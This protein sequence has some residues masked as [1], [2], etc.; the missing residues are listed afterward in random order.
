M[1]DALLILIFLMLLA[2]VLVTALSMV[3][4]LRRRSGRT[5]VENGVPTRGI[6]LGV[7]ALLAGSLVFTFLLGS[8]EPLSIN[9]EDFTSV[10]WLKL[11]DMFIFT[12]LILIVIAA[13]GV[14]YGMSGLNRRRRNASGKEVR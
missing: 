5:G 7:A 10:F 6:S 4:S 13:G 2:A 3:R 9:G 14:V 8:S 1:V 11:T 12:A